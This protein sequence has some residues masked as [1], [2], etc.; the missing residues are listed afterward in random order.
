[1]FTYSAVIYDGK[2]Q[3]LVRYECRTD[4]EFSSYLESRFGC[5]VC[6]WSNK[7]LSENTMAAIAASRQLIEK[8]NVDKTE[9]L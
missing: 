7:E 9:A 6:L 3:N 8:D 5:H 4:T 1:M 2:K